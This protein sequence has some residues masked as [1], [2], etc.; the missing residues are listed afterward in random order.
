MPLAAFPK[1]FLPA[2][3]ERRMSVE[4]WVELAAKQLS[5][6]GLELYWGFLDPEEAALKSLRRRIE[7]CGLRVPMMCYSPDFTQPDPRLRADEVER[8]RQAIIGSAVLG[9]R[10][11]RV[12]SGQSR[13][14]VS[15]RDGIAMAAECIGGLLPFAQKHGV[16]LILEN[17]YKDGFWRYPEFAQRMDM[18]LEL[19]AAIPANPAFGVNYDP[20]NA[21]IAGD[22]PIALLNAV[23]DR[24][25][26]I[27][28][29]DRYFEGGSAAELRRLERDPILGYA[30]FLKHGVI[31]KG[32]I[33]YNG[34]FS[35]LRSV[36]F[37]GWIS[38]ED[39]DDPAV[40]IGHLQESVRF[41]RERM[42]AF[43]LP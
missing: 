21:L 4:S 42:A 17:H 12:L 35:V 32:S 26:T 30:P 14:E 20:S 16:C 13:P 1:C 36:G 22:D 41:L 25:V 34:I 3:V 43:G 11:C 27:H 38:I 37:R 23:K 29:S 39:G 33:D 31:G 2:M 5:V 10:Y 40:G 8:Q 15:R 28:A 24:V 7:A 18:F 19:L 9:A 6:D